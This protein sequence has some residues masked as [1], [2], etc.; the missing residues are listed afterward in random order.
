METQI[1][2]L[3]IQDIIKKTLRKFPLITDTFSCARVR[4]DESCKTAYTD[5]KD[6]YYNP[7]FLASLTSDEQIFVVAH[8][9]MHIAFQHIPR[10]LGKDNDTWNIA[11]DAVINKILESE[12]LAIKKGLVNMDIAVNKTAEEMYEY[13][14]KNPDAYKQKSKDHNSDDCGEHTNWE[15]FAK[16]NFGSKKPEQESTP[17]EKDFTSKNKR[18]QK[19]IAEKIMKKITEQKNKVSEMFG[20]MSSGSEVS[21]GEVGKGRRI[22]D[23]KKILKKDYDNE[24]YEWS[25]RRANAENGYSARIQRQY[26]YDK[27]KTEVILDTSG[28]IDDD[29]LKGFLRQIKNL[30]TDSIIY[31]GCFDTEFYGFTPIHSNKDIDNFVIKGRGGTNLD[32]AVRA[33]SR[34]T[35]VNKII[36]TDGYGTMPENDLKD[37]NVKWL[38]FNNNSFAPCC[39]KVIYCDAKQ[40]VEEELSRDV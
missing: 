7:A 8:E 34:D 4:I 21:F 1:P 23:W 10:T 15:D 31:A 29:L 20:K 22:L 3:D 28:S 14:I 32:I 38:I 9:A 25:Y 11:T 33:F 26:N 30:L 39:G 19:E 17:S 13:L 35:K 6:I 36:F 12:S 37:V 40:I 5:G 24:K 2:N 18:K 16:S 27:R